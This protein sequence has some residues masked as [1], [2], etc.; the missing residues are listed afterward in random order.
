MIWCIVSGAFGNGIALAAEILAE[1]VFKGA[2]PYIL[3]IGGGFE[4][5]SFQKVSLYVVL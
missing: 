1:M 4:E 3:D 5:H 2:D